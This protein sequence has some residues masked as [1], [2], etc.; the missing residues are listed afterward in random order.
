MSV[1]VIDTRQGRTIIAKCKP[2]LTSPQR[3]DDGAPLGNEHALVH[4]VGSGGVRGAA[5]DRD[6]P[7]AQR[8]GNNGPDILQR[9]QVVKGGQPVPS[10]DTVQLGLGFG[11][12]AVAK[13]DASEDEAG[14][15]TRRLHSVS[16]T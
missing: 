2:V 6:G 8:L 5:Q 16:L 15:R 4:I 12:E 14:E 11:D 13:L 3:R 7:P 1:H 10:H 9:W